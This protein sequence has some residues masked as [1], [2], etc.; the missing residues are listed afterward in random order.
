MIFHC[1]DMG[2][3]FYGNSRWFLHVSSWTV[4]LSATTPFN[5]LTIVSQGLVLAC[6]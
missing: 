1:D 6:P 4:P 3:V 2:D 5:T